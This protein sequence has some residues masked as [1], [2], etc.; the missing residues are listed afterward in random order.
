MWEICRAHVYHLTTIFR[1][2]SSNR[3]VLRWFLVSSCYSFRSDEVPT[4]TL[5]SKTHSITRF[6]PLLCGY[7][8]FALSSSTVVQRAPLQLILID[9]QMGLH[10]VAVIKLFSFKLIPIIRSM[11]NWSL[12]FVSGLPIFQHLHWSLSYLPWTALLGCRRLSLQIFGRHSSD[13]VTTTR[14]GMVQPPDLI[15]LNVCLAGS[16]IDRFRAAGFGKTKTTAAS[17]AD[18]AFINFG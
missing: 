2:V 6:G 16:I 12:S 9:L 10:G 5:N 13:D 11:R 7:F 14:R 18:Y 8:F 17:R 4:R 1:R 3:F 15:C